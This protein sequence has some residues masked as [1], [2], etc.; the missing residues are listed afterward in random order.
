MT[1]LVDYVDDLNE[2]GHMDGFED[3]NDLFEDNGDDELVAGQSGNF[4]NNLVNDDNVA[5]IIIDNIRLANTDDVESVIIDSDFIPSAQ[6]SKTD[7]NLNDIFNEIEATYFQSHPYNNPQPHHF[8]QYYNLQSF[9]YPQSSQLYTQQ[10]LNY[11]QSNQYY[12]RQSINNPQSSQYNHQQANHNHQVITKKTNNN[13]STPNDNENSK[14]RGKPVGSK[15]K[16][17]NTS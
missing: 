8:P 13:K 7:F 1:M 3:S 10:S 6:S 12:T 4:H 2:A 11:P 14:K 15:N 17:K 16:T 5:S 9:N